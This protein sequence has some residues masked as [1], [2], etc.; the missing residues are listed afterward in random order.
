MKSWEVFDPKN[1]IPI[2][3]FRLR[4]VAAFI[5]RIYGYDYEQTGVCH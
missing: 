5:A 3:T 4:V 2:W 1:G